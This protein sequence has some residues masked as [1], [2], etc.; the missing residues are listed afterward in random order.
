MKASLLTLLVACTSPQTGTSIR[1]ST[2][3]SASGSCLNPIDYG[4]IP[5][6]GISDRV[7]FQSALDAA[8]ALPDGGT[9]CAGR[10]R[11]TMD[12]APA[13]SY[14]R[15]AAIATHAHNVT[16]TG[17]GPETI[18]ELVGDQ[19]LGDIAIVSID[20]GA[21]HITVQD[22]TIDTS[23][24]FNTSEQTHALATSA[25]CN[26]TTCAPI[27]D[28]AIRHVTFRHPKVNDERKGDCLRL[29]GGSNA[30][31]VDRVHVEDATFTGCARAGIE[32]QRNVHGLIVSG[33][34]FSGAMDTDID[35]EPT[36]GTMDL[37]DTIVISGNSFVDDPAAQGD[38]TLTLGG[39]GAPMS[40][41]IVTG[42]V[43]LGR[44]IALYRTGSVV[45][46]G[47]TF[48]AT[49]KG[50]GGV[51][52]VSN[53]C[54]GLV[55]AHNSISR[56]ASAGPMIRLTP[57]SG[58]FCGDVIIDHNVL[59]Q[60]TA[61][62]GIYM[63]SASHITIDSNAMTWTVAAP[64]FAAI[65]ARA[66]AAVVTHLQITRNR[67]FGP[68]TYGAILSSSPFA[69]GGGVGLEG[70]YAEGPVFGVYCTGSGGFAPITSYGNSLGPKVCAGVTFSTGD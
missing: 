22:L 38:Y 31:R 20:P 58:G 26:A 39:M 66:I 44:G 51:I 67:I 9:V 59:T 33:S 5:N 57:H 60:S 17:V 19:A 34:S 12:R 45:M 62:Y 35:S 21:Q 68:V 15:L 69:F 48:A 56:A 2:V 18:L 47:N 54:A 28:I 70:N 11:W 36:G 25:M 23:T 7:P 55:V 43:F 63:E 13:G 61:G 64:Q 42:N 27:S 14:N 52:E 29:L 1:A 53:V 6:D 24:A 8:G 32:I 49:M 16:L 30:T 46:E 4:A 37:N 41:V 40:G 10:G 50:L 3:S 65:Y